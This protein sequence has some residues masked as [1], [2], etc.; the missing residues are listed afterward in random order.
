MA[1]FGLVFLEKLEQYYT[2]RLNAAMQQGFNDSATKYHWLYMELKLRAETIGQVKLFLSLLPEYL[3]RSDSENAMTFAT[4]YADV[5]FM[6]QSVGQLPHN[7]NGNCSYFSEGNP[8]WADIQ[9]AGAGLNRSQSEEE[10]LACITE[11]VICCLRLYFYMRE[12]QFRAIDREK[13]EHLMQPAGD[14]S[15]KTEV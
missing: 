4:Q 11:Y 13:F 10:T 1:H 15:R 14:R 5:W 7:G 9:T 3:H 8:Y 6:E 2:A 12:H